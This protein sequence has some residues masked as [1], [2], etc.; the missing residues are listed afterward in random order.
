MR[1]YLEFDSAKGYPAASDLFYQCLRCGD[2]V[3]SIPEKATRC[4]CHNI[5][6]DVSYA[7]MNILEPAKAKLFREI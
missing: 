6:V 1:E 3:P 4:T 5:L 7:R 2:I